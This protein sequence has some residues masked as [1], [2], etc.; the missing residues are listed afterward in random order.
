MKIKSLKIYFVITLFLLFVFNISQAVENNIIF[1]IKDKAF[2]KVDYELRVQYLD[3]VGSNQYLNKETI[4]SDFISANLFYEHFL[5]KKNYNIKE[6]EIKI[7]EIFTNIYYTNID[8][9]KKYKYE[10]NKSN[11]LKNI[12]IDYYRKL[13]LEEILN[14]NINNI[15][16]SSKD[17]DLLY[18]IN[19]SYINFSNENSKELYERII[20]LEEINIDTVQDLLKKNNINF[21]IKQKEVI[22]NIDKIDSRIKKNILSNNNLFI[23]DN[24]NEYSIIFIDKKFETFESIIVNLFSI[25]SDSKLDNQ[26]LNCKNLSNN[27][28]LETIN[29]EYKYENLNEEL[30]NNL[31]NVNDYILFNNNNENIYIVLCDIKFDQ[32]ILQNY[33]FN[34]LINSNVSSIE[35]KLIDKYAKM[36]NLIKINA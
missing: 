15:S 17:I 3:F 18:N 26:I 1:K 21:F 5:T 25:R 2:T 6:L 19:I 9:N 12:K 23:L 20:N 34:K 27:N 33:N 35:K 10:I 32:N 22:N 30:K 29:K 31:I 24:K 28:N 7:E 11:I 4:L 13:I 36:Y 16:V 14:T 8:N